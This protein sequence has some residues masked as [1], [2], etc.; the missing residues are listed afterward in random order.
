MY[1]FLFFEVTVAS[2][3]I[4]AAFVDIMAASVCILKIQSHLKKQKFVQKLS[5]TSIE[6]R[7]QY[8]ALLLL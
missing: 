2:K 5:E 4:T 1:K 3:D 6:S 8:G 7:S